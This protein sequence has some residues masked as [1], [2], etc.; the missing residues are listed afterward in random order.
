MSDNNKFLACMEHSCLRIHLVLVQYCT[1][2][3]RDESEM[4]R[5]LVLHS[6]YYTHRQ[7]KFVRPLSLDFF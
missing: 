2:S 4:M 6:S 7:F 5:L 1:Q 3:W